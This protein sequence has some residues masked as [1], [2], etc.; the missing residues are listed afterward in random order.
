[1]LRIGTLTFHQSTNYGG[2]LQAYALQRALAECGA[3][4]K[5]VNYKCESIYNGNTPLLITNFSL[6]GILG[7]MLRVYPQIKKNK[8]FKQFRKQYMTITEREYTRQNI[9]E[10]DKEFDTFVTGSDQVWRLDLT[11]Y[12][13]TYFLDFTQK[14]KYAYSASLGAIAPNKVD[15]TFFKEMLG[16]YSGVSVREKETAVALQILLKRKVTWT[17]DPVFLLSQ[18]HWITLAGKRIENKPYIFVFRLHDTN[19]YEYAERLKKITGLKVISLESGLRGMSKAKQ[20]R[21]VKVEEFLNYINYAEYIVTDSFHCTAFALIF[22][23]QV[24]PILQKSN[25]NMNNRLVSLMSMVKHE[26]CIVSDAS[27]QLRNACIIDYNIVMPLLNDEINK[28]KKYLKL[29][30]EAQNDTN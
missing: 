2:I 26:S 1:M 28:A 10:V 17:V 15:E 18:Q 13:R 24:H 25:K 22:N 11:G 8:V 3:D 20:I 21:S 9:V 30:C 29:I 19:V 4:S 12:D 27:E 5:I 23:R 16:T 6:R 7:A 14:K